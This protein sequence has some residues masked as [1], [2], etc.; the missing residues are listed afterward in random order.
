MDLMLII[1]MIA[2]SIFFMFV[3]TFLLEKNGI[4]NIYLIYNVIAFVLSFKILKV[5]E[6]NI[7]ASIVLSSLF[8]SLTYFVI[9]KT[10]PKEYK[11]IIFETLIIN[12]TVGLMM[13]ISSLYVG[14]IEDNTTIHMNN[15]FLDN[16]KIL[17]S[18]P[19]VTTITQVLTLLIY[20][21]IKVDKLSTISRIIITNLNIIMIDSILF[22]I[23]SYIFKIKFNQIII[24]IIS[25]YLIKVLITSLYTPFINYMI[26]KK[27][28]KLWI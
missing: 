11:D 23:T 3:S 28:V 12:L 6:I 18:Y 10:T 16:Y 15:I 5:F 27:K 21:N 2:L 20:N 4:K 14:T 26:S 17:I 7:S 25:N 13:F 22:F 19:I 1:L 9:E 24:L 8:I